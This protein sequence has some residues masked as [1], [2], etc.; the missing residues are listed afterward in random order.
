MYDDERESYER[1]V[2]EARERLGDERLAALR[3]Q[4][5]ERG[6]DAAVALALT[7]VAVTGRLRLE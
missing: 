1:T 4:G 7:S 2:D 5:H 3:G 6:T